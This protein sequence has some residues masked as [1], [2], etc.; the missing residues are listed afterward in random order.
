M[1]RISLTRARPGLLFAGMFLACAVTA[2]QEQTAAAPGLDGKQAEP[3]TNNGPRI[4]FPEPSF[5][6][7]RVESGKVVN[8]V[9]EFTNAGNQLLEIQDVWTSCGC[10]AVTNWTRKVEPAKSGKIPIIFD[11]A[12]RAG[13]VTKT[14]SVACNDPA[15]PKLVLQFTATIWKP[16]DAIPA[17]AAFNFGPDFQTNQS[18]IIQL[19]SNLEEPVSIS[20]PVC[21]NSAFRAELTTLKEGKEFE[22]QVTV[23]PPVASGSTVTPITLKTSS[24]NMPVVTVTAYAVVQPS[25]TVTPPRLRL[26]KVPLTDAAQFKIRI[27]N[28]STNSL[29]L[30]DP[31]I[32]EKGA[33]VRLREVQ[34]GRLFELTVSFPT[35]FRVHPGKEMEVRVKSNHPQFPYVRIPV[36]EPFASAGE[37]TTAASGL[38]HAR[39]APATAGQSLQ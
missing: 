33:E 30:S 23:V 8:H 9:F 26:P 6:F 24:S 14:V 15:Q 5:D 29:V 11:S 37:D 21:T 35:G 19:V 4:E 22:L 27:Q 7:G 36:L 32:S 2:A 18:R 12:G 16:I 34:P 3:A 28:Q 1:Q 10:T 25:L 39:D 38:F 31:G 20:K 13:P 17:I